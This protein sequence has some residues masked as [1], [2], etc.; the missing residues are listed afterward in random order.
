MRNALHTIGTREINVHT[1]VWYKTAF[2]V[3][4]HGEKQMNG[5]HRETERAGLT[6][7]CFIIIIRLPHRAMLPQFFSIV[8]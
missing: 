7:G 6:L 8:R 4:C 3:S 2:N 1:A 5:A